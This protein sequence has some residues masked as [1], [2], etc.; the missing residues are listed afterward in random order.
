M[1][2]N[3]L[4]ILKMKILVRVSGLNL[5]GSTKK[6]RP[7]TGKQRRTVDPYNFDESESAAIDTETSPP[8]KVGN[9]NNYINVEK[10]EQEVDF[11]KEKED[12]EKI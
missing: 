1:Q 6:R 12:Q 8:S 5:L 2:S 11:W 3:S 9:N 4:Q 10:E 7:K